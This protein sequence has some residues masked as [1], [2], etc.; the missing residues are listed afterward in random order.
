M[1]NAQQS[2][3]FYSTE[4]PTDRA[5]GIGAAHVKTTHSRI[6]KSC[7]FQTSAIFKQN[8]YQF[9]LEKLQ[10]AEKHALK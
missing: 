4:R 5:G 3:D 1:S 2:T 8:K 10:K 6:Q 9:H 7:R